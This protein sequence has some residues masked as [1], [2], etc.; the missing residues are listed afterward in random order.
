[1]PIS[2]ITTNSIASNTITSGIL[3]TGQTLSVNGITFPATQVSSADANT[4]DDY[5][6]GTFTATLTSSTPPSSPPTT[7]AYYTKTGRMVT[8]AMRFGNVNTSGGSGAMYITGLPFTPTI[9]P[10]DC[11]TAITSMYGF[12]FSGSWVAAYASAGSIYFLS[13]TSGGAW[14][15]M[16]ITAGSGKYI[17]FSLTY[18]VA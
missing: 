9:T 7:T 15:D 1:M 8:V 3:A 12:S 18:Q 6:E 11:Y 5:E 16:S 2:Q 13:T 17:Q 4:L 10:S 14:S